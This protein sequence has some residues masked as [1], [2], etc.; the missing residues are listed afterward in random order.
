MANSSLQISS[1]DFDTLKQN[2]KNFLAS[3]S[4]FKDYDF[5]GSNINVLLDVMSYNS[6]LNSFYLNM[7]ASEMFLDSAQKLDS[8]ISHAKELNYLPRSN[9]SPKAVVSFNLSTNGVNNPLI[10][11]KGTTFSGINSN[12]TYTFVTSVE[13][14]FLSSDTT[15]AI[16][17]LQIYEGSYIQE[18][19]VVDYSIETQKFI[20]SNPTIDT[21]SLEV[22]V[23]ENN[24]NTIH[25]YATTLFGLSSNSAVYFLQATSEK[26][27]EVL[28]GD[29]VFG[30]KPKNGAI[31]TANYRIT[32]GSDGNGVST[33]NLDSDLGPVNGGY[34]TPSAIT[35]VSPSISGANSE[36]IESIRFNAPRHYQTQGRCITD[37]DY[38]TVVLQNYPE[39]QYVSVYGGDVTNTA[40]NFGTVFI[41]PSTYSGTILNDTRKIDVETYLNKLSPIGIR[42]KVINPDYLYISV[43]SKIHVNFSN[44][45]SSPPSIITKATT[46]VKTYNSENL[47]NFNTAFRLSRLEQTINECDTGVISN[48]TTTKMF[49]VYTPEINVSYS[50]SF[51]YYNPVEKGSLQS[52]TFVSGG[53]TYILTDYIEGVDT[54]NGKIYLY[55]QTLIQS[56]ANYSVVGSINYSTGSVVINSIEYFNVFG[57]LKIYASPQNKDIYCKGNTIIEID[58]VSGLSFTTV[59]N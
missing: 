7:I 39:I 46:A 31:I 56:A 57:G 34:A 24:T 28:F 8:V 12:G 59:S 20:L 23:N 51:E 33:F 41:S 47:Q 36:G 38:E 37:S 30:K 5:E 9:R 40:V 26:K 6:Y 22:I 35:V 50:I 52:S 18:S 27:Y 15:Y 32:S 19:F 1:L 49:K 13:Q 11:P 10:I 44:T 53:K 42:V 4:V 2:F 16:S 48:E 21:D 3:Q 45:T 17:N 54:G 43:N 58:T 55:E 25:S 29:D 14:S